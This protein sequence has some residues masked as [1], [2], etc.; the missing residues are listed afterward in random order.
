MVPRKCS[1]VS[2]NG[3]GEIRDNHCRAWGRSSVGQSNRLII[4]RPL[5]R[6]QPPP[7]RGC[8]PVT[9]GFVGQS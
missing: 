1:L 2:P 8:E 5:V 4:D 9:R 7:P 6:V 3:A